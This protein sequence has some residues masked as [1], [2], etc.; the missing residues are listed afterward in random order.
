LKVDS[1][2]SPKVTKRFLLPRFDPALDFRT[3]AAQ[4]DA[5]VAGLN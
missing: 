1:F 3:S 2:F 5:G 4:A